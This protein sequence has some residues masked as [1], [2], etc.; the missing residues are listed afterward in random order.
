MHIKFYSFLMLLLVL[1]WVNAQEKTIH[2][3]KSGETLQT[4]ANQYNV[5]L[6]NLK[7]TNQKKVSLPKEGDTIVVFQQKLVPPKKRPIDLLPNNKKD[8]KKSGVDIRRNHSIDTLTELQENKKVKIL[9]TL[10]FNFK[11]N[12]ELTK[13]ELFSNQQSLPN[14]VS[15][16]YMGAKVATDSLINQGLDLD[17]HVLD[18]NQFTTLN[19]EELL[20]W[21]NYQPDIVIGS[22]FTKEMKAIANTF[23]KSLVY[24]PIYSKNQSLLTEGNIVQT[25][26]DQTVFPF[27]MIEYIRKNRT[28]EKII[29]VGELSELELLKQYQKLLKKDDQDLL[30]EIVVPTK[31]YLT[32]QDIRKKMSTT[33]NNWVLLVSENNVI[34]SDLVN[35]LNVIARQ[36]RNA[37]RKMPIRLFTFERTEVIEKNTFKLLSAIGY[38][39]GTDLYEYSD[40]TSDLFYKTYLEENYHYP[41]NFSARGFAVTYSAIINY[42]RNTPQIN[43]IRAGIDLK[44]NMEANPKINTAYYINMLQDDALKGISIM[45]LQ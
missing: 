15:E 35:N 41:T 45:R 8:L 21:V 25:A 40:L 31:G 23:N 17:V 42:L 39:Y 5:S 28:S 27:K 36:L 7:F 3:V 44:I 2:I 30:V 38:T 19:T 22:F 13:E 20:T 37:Q 12:N 33:L 18:T 34:V 24:Y 16:F 1:S 9:L 11:K 26:A 29:L 43:D 32:Q 4:I 10:P 14:L 6:E